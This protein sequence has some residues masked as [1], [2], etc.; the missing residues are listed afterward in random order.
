M[1]SKDYP[2][3][4]IIPIE[5]P[6]CKRLKV[7]V[8]VARMQGRVNGTVTNTPINRVVKDAAAKIK[9]TVPIICTIGEKKRIVRHQ[10]IHQQS[11]VLSLGENGIDDVK[12][13]NTN[14]CA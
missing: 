7:I 13:K 12:Q 5:I 8:V 9:A 3:E 11:L 6:V 1:D 4:F 10:N 14:D 2:L